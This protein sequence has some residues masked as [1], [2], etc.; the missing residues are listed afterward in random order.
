ML[1]IIYSQSYITLILDELNSPYSKVQVETGDGGEGRRQCREG[2][3]L[4]RAAETSR[5][6]RD[7]SVGFPAAI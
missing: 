7:D 2:C 4:C 6:L 1:H 5:D 3:V